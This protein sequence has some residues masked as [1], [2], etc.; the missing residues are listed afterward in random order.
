MRYCNQTQHSEIT[1]FVISVVLYFS[2]NLQDLDRYLARYFHFFDYLTLSNRIRPEKTVVLFILHCQSM[3]NDFSYYD[4]CV[5]VV[6]TEHCE[7][8]LNSKSIRRYIL[9]ENISGLCYSEIDLLSLSLSL[10]LIC[11]FPSRSL[12]KL[13]RSNEGSKFSCN[14]VSS[15]R[16]WIV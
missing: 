9:T 12:A 8:I 1:H 4:K 3:P 15:D 6:K 16:Y 10:S 2:A 13:A 5:F 7:F 11:I 14:P